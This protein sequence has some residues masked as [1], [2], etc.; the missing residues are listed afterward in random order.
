LDLTIKG[1]RIALYR[2]RYEEIQARID[3]LDEYARRE[4]KPFE[5]ERKAYV[6]LQTEIRQAVAEELGQS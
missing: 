3:E 1:N 4:G 2:R 6:R 5:S